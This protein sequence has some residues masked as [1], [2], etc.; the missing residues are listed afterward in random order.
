MSN[1]VSRIVI[2]VALAPVVLVAVYF[3][4]WWM[5]ALVALAAAI[6]LHE[7]TL[8]ARALA[9]KASRKSGHRAR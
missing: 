5:F 3:G 2:S 6:A 9:P 8:M 1:A 7:Y 4:D